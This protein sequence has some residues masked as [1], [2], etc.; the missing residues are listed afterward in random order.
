MSYIYPVCPECGCNTV[1]LFTPPKRAFF[2]ETP[3]NLDNIDW[4]KSHLYCA[5][6]STNC[7][8]KVLLTE[9]TTPI[10][11]KRYRMLCALHKIA[12]GGNK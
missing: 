3:V 1:V 8:F 10:L 5:N 4:A 12:E 2:Y 11:E 9:L 7:D 6:G